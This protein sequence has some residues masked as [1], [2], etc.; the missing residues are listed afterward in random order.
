MKYPKIKNVVPIENYKVII[1]YET[2]EIK[3]F[4]VKPYITGEWYGELKDLNIFRSVRPCGN[5]IEWLNGQDIAPH[6]LYEL[7]K[8]I[9]YADEIEAI[10]RGE[11]ELKN[12]EVYSHD[13]V[14]N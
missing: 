14:W 7:S 4:D 2:G 5:T 10:K 9:H 3:S 11:A 12:G 13:E 6:E 8:S 1:T